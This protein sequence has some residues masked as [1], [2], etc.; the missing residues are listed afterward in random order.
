MDPEIP[1]FGMVMFLFRNFADL[2]D[3]ADF[4]NDAEFGDAA[5]LG[6]PGGGDVPEGFVMILMK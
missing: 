3:A 2:T 5:D 1:D 4:E 6:S